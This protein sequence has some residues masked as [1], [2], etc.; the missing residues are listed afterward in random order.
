MIE[1][2]SGEISELQPAVAVID[3]HGIGYEINITVIDYT[4][5]KDMKSARLYVHESIREDA[6]LLFGFLDRHTRQLFRLLIGVS[7]VGP[8]TA[9]LILSSLTAQQLSQTIASGQDSMLKAV[10]GIGAKTAQRII[11]DLRDKIKAPQATLI[12]SGIPHADETYQDA[13]QALLMLGF[14]QPL[15]QK[16]MQKIFAENPAITTELAVAQALKMI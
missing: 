6:H 14:A 7:G 5:M 9:R 11:V 12:S 13:V 15:T 3:C 10:K 8:N 4:A 2:I 1:Y 16:V